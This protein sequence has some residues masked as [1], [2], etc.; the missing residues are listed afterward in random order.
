M[1]QMEATDVGDVPKLTSLISGKPLSRSEVFKIKGII[2]L[3][4]ENTP[5]M[6]LRFPVE[7][8]VRNVFWIHKLDIS[9]RHLS[10]IFH[11]KATIH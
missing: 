4:A 11:I 1:P 3:T 5:E 10:Q 7:K 6:S 8:I 2:S 9:D